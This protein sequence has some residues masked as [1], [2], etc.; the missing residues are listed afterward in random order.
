MG[1]KCRICNRDYESWHIQK[2]WTKCNPG[3][4]C[5][6]CYKVWSRLRRRRS[7]MDPLI[8]QQEAEAHARL[9]MEI[10]M[11]YSPNLVCQRCEFSDIRA[12]SIDH[13][14]GGGRQ[15]SR[16]VGNFYLWLRR[17]HYPSGFQVLCMNCQAIKRLE[18]H[19]CANKKLPPPPMNMT[20]HE[21][22]VMECRRLGGR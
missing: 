20:L 10:L 1:S 18:N 6:P 22:T 14:Y 4:I 13:I 19:E 16:R 3:W 9:K 17:N 5:R 2:G 11:H 12:L 7:R 21:E 8:K 15:H